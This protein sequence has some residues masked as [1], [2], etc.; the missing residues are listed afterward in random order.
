MSYLTLCKTLFLLTAHTQI[1]GNI[2][3]STNYIKSEYNTLLRSYILSHS[4]SPVKHR[5]YFIIISDEIKK[6]FEIHISDWK[7]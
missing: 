4:K 6:T 2:P 1:I 7:S 5:K 3:K